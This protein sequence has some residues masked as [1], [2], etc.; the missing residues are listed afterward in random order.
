MVSRQIAACVVRTGCCDC[1]ARAVPLLAAARPLEAER[2]SP[3]AL[4]FSGGGSSAQGA[5]S[6]ADFG[7]ARALT[8]FFARALVPAF[9]QAGCA[10]LLTAGAPF[11]SAASS[12]SMRASDWSSRA[13]PQAA[14]VDQGA[15]EHSARGGQITHVRFAPQAADLHSENEPRFRSGVC[16]RKI[17]R[18][19]VRGAVQQIS[20]LPQVLRAAARESA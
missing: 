20:H 10:G 7:F 9:A 12:R 13:R 17:A 15:F 19:C 14:N 2:C 3:P 1:R 16:L 18:H 11:A 8:P 4:R 5:G 6:G